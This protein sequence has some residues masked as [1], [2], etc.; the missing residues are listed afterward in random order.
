MIH[1]CEKN[2]GTRLVVTEY[3]LC[4]LK[5]TVGRFFARLISNK[6]R[7]RKVYEA[8]CL[9][10]DNLFP[11]SLPLAFFDLTG[12]NQFSNG[13]IAKPTWLTMTMQICKKLTLR[14]LAD[15]T[16]SELVLL[17]I[18]ANRC[19]IASW[20]TVAFVHFA[21]AGIRRLKFHCTFSPLFL[22]FQFRLS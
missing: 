15:E 9:C 5:W 16:H 11:Y 19:C 7:H 12:L 20:R 18:L 4:D 14:L 2:R 13:S 22:T 3:F 6:R 10:T 21:L 1:G 8:L 17:L